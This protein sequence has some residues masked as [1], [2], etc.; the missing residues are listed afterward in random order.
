[1]TVE[2]TVGAE[3]WRLLSFCNIFLIK[4]NLDRGKSA[5]NVE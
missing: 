3:T 4:L 1:M 5:I 2:Q